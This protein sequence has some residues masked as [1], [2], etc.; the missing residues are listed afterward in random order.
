MVACTGAAVLRGRK[1]VENP[2]ELGGRLRLRR[3]PWWCYFL[4]GV[5]VGLAVEGIGIHYVALGVIFDGINGGVGECHE[6]A[7][8][9]GAADSGG[10]QRAEGEDGEL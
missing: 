5:F 2:V 7:A 6:P 1:A 9:T 8:T 10:E 3:V 4:A